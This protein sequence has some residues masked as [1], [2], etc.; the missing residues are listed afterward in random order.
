MPVVVL[1]TVGRRTRKLRKAPIMRV[2][3][4]GTYAAV[5]SLGGA[6]N[7]PVWVYNLR[8]NPEVTLQDGPTVY[9]LRARELAGAERDVWWTRSVAAYPPYADYQA[10]TQRLIPVFVLEPAT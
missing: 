7:N 8:A 3:H 4:Q 9:D 6:P 5:G 2:E 1:T 10:R